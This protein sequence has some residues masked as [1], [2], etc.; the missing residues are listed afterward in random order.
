[1]NAPLLQSLEQGF[2]A[3]PPA[4]VQAAQLGE[5]RRASLAAA[6]RDGLPGA[7]AE[8]W[9]H[10]SLR[11]LERRAFS[12]LA[13]ADEEAAIRLADK[14]TADQPADTQDAPS[15]IRV[16]RQL[17]EQRIPRLV[18]VN[19]GFAPAL[20][21]LDGLPA[22][23]S[24]V[25]LSRA[26]ADPARDPRELEFLARRFNAADE[27]FA[28]LNAAFALDGLLLR[29]AAGVQ[30][31]QPLALVMLGAKA[32]ADHA[33]HL[34]HLVELGEGASLSLREYQF[35]ATAQ[36]NLCNS[37]TQVHLR[38][39]ARLDHLRVQ[40]EDA[41]AT[42]FTRTDAVLASEGDYHRTDLELGAALS[43]HELNVALQGNGARLRSSGVLLA[44]GRRHL[45]T[46][47]GID[48]AARD[49]GCELTWRGLGAE[50]GRA[51]FHG[52]IL[53]RAG[54]DGT[55]AQLSNKNL[56][57]SANAEIDTQ[58]VLEIHA[59]EVKASHGATVGQLDPAAL[60]YLRSRGV[61]EVQARRQLTE[62]FCR[63][64]L[65]DLADAALREQIDALL[66]QRLAGVGA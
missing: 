13:A 5:A 43:R 52:G 64:V 61:P 2:A 9:R 12:P 3:L 66:A 18:F 55:S 4:A 47:L 60:F 20:S 40:D 50:R 26:L 34:R 35:A 24:L 8:R 63:I 58:P 28:R 57:L 56:L 65:D 17:F 23:V 11:S 7:R 6:L 29:V 42:L 14:M 37:L 49:T 16:L 27:T 44:D 1:M 38:R 31:A 15:W 59:D 48:H 36:T 33:V 53:I 19:G 54:A 62:A 30:C 21:Q 45:D 41:G 46:R 10:T 32:D 51:V 39:G 25:P 22:G